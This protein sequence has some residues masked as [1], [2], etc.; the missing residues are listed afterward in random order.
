MLGDRYRIEEPL[1]AGGFGQVYRAVQLPLERHVAVKLLPPAALASSERLARFEREAELAQRLEHPNTVRMLDYGV[2][3]DG[4]P[5]LVM[6]LL[7]GETL[8]T[9]LDREGG[10]SVARTAIIACDVLKSLMEAHALGIVHR[11]VK[12]A[13]IFLTAYAGEPLFAR[14]L[15]FGVAKQL[16]PAAPASIRRP[17][18]DTSKSGA[19]THDSQVMGTPRYMA[20]EQVAGETIGPPA[21][22]HALGLTLAEALTGRPVY[23]DEDPI[24]VCLAHMSEDP[25]PLDALVTGSALGAIIGRAVA[26]RIEDRFVSAEEM[27]QAIEALRATLTSSAH[28]HP[29]AIVGGGAAGPS[30]TAATQATPPLSR[31]LA[32]DTT[33][34]GVDWSAETER[35]PPTAVGRWTA[36]WKIAVAVGCVAALASGA[37]IALRSRSVDDARGPAPSATTSASSAMVVPSEPGASASTSAHPASPPTEPG[38]PAAP[39]AR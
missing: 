15:D 10:Q 2:S 1:G 4:A 18:L 5:F 6:E 12:P 19:L 34:V 13:N 32:K 36:R 29:A 3:A 27:L 30:E 26:K 7:R 21:D 31:K 8:R 14:L 17:S 22:L 33:S 11:D 20:P 16:D 38:S 35:T 9:L 39:S 28:N 25:V 37:A 24:E 23:G